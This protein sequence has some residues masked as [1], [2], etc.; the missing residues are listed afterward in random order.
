[1]I[2]TE[3]GQTGDNFAKGIHLDATIDDV[4][5]HGWEGAPSI[6]GNFRIGLND[7]ELHRLLELRR[8]DCRKRSHEPARR[9]LP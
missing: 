9:G 5:V 1:L 3:D 8:L 2:L 4:W 6:S 7:P